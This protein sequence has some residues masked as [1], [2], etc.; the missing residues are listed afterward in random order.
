M[1]APGPEKSLLERARRNT[2]LIAAI[3]ACLAG[4]ARADECPQPVRAAGTERPAQQQQP[5]TELA[6]TPIEYEADGVD[7][8]RDGEWLLQGD[9]LIRQGERTLKTRNAKYNSAAQSFSVDEAVEYAD[10]NL[11]V[12]GTSASVDQ[13]GGATFE[14][15]QFELKERNARGSADRI[16]V[17]RDNQLKLNAVRYTT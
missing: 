14:G 13:T 16:Q 6:D 11:K 10:P 9:V 8:T 12:S 2:V 4:G 7:A 3:A 15:A 1:H 17:T 5:A